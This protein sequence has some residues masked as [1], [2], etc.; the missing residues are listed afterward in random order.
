MLAMRAYMRAKTVDGVLMDSIAEGVGLAG[1][2]I[3]AMY[4]LMAIANYEDR[5]VIPT[6]HR[7][8]GEDTFNL[9]GSCGFS[10]GDGCNSK[11]GFDLFGGGKAKPKT[12]MEVV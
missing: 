5:F 12:P 6:A 7:E 2:D 1:A 3:E 8:T 9:R 10:F 4:Q 11:T